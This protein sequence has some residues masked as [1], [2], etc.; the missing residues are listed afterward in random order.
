MTGPIT[1]ASGLASTAAG[2]TGPWPVP[3]GLPDGVFEVA[4]TLRRQACALSGELQPS[5]EDDEDGRLAELLTAPLRLDHPW[6]APAAP[7]AVAGGWVHAEVIDDDRSLLDMLLDRR[8]SSGP[9]ETAARCQELRLPVSP[10]RPLPSMSGRRP[11]HASCEASSACVRPPEDLSL[12][13]PSPDNLSLDNPSPDDLPLDNTV[14]VDLTTHW[15]GPLITKLLAEAGA[16]VIK[17][18][19][20]CRPDGFRAR[21]NLYH[22]LNGAKEIIDLDLRNGQH[23]R[24]FEGLLAG[25]DLLVES[26]SRRVLA[27]LGYRPCDLWA[28]APR[29][30]MLSV[31]A[32]AAGSPER[33]W[34][35]YGPG[36]HAAS[37]L[38]LIG[39]QPTP[40]PLAYPDFLTGLTGYLAALRLL[41]HGAQHRTA[42]R[43]VEVSLAA[44]IEPLVARARMPADG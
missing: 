3:A 1:A 31:K 43:M 8:P 29:L 28:L 13:N 17:I 22:H 34:L 44:G 4:R 42:H 39:R 36:V 12:D 7:V 6:P 26:F 2:G 19:P 10:Y 37:G 38:G 24:R 11:G 16:S 18:D 5:S 30:S 23:R 15:A 40:A 25:A 35:A 33:N 20:D 41:H 32:Y 27:N 9:E 14:V 21:P